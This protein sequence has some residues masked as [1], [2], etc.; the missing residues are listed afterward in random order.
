MLTFSPH[1]CD[2]AETSLVFEEVDQHLHIYGCTVTHDL[3]KGKYIKINCKLFH[4][5]K[6]KTNFL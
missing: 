4:F 2:T 5:V 6:K 1:V 3:T